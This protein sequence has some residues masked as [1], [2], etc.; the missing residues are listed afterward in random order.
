MKKNLD[1]VSVSLLLF[2]CASWGLNQVAIKAAVAEIP[3]VLQ[4]A[5]RSVGS[6]LLLFAWMRFK[7]IPIFNSDGTLK[8]GLLVGGLFTMEFILIF[9]GLEYTTASRSVIFLNTA[10]FVVALGAQFLIPGEGLTPMKITGMLLAFAGIVFAFN[11]D[12]GTAGASTLTG[13]I[14]LLAA[15]VLWGL[16]TICIKISPLAR[17]PAAKTLLYQL[18]SSSVGMSVLSVVMGE[19]LPGMPG[20]V[21]LFS[22][23]YQIIWVAFFTYL[24]WFW[25]LTVYPASLLA[26]FM[27]LTPLFG[28]LAGALLLGEPLTLHLMGALALVA[29]GIYLVNRK[30]G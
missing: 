18:T 2:L 30:E 8:W 23:G 10:P 12:L 25:L 20:G 29:T 7:K 17:I 3:P 9:W 4:A 6:G 1:V 28:V 24:V 13:D 16:T 14:M 22:I 11:D 21:A 27:F 15:A 5:V 19:S 26:P